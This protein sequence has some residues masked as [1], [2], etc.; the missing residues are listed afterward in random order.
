MTH[1]RRYSGISKVLTINYLYLSRVRGPW[2]NG[3]RFT[4]WEA[5][6]LPGGKRR[7]SRLFER[8]IGRLRSIICDYFYIVIWEYSG[9]FGLRMEKIRIYIG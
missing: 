5:V 2:K 4:S 6:Y 9:V 7:F 3:V 8:L 1:Q